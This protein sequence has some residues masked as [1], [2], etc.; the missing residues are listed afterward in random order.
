M[1]TYTTT[2]GDTWD[3][4]AYELFGIESRMLNL[5]QANP[6][7]LNTVIFGAGIELQIPSLPDEVQSDLPPWKRV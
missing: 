1:T 4:I 7:H 3:S 2:Q 5:M 6:D